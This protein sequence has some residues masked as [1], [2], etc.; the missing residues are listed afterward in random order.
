MKLEKTWWLPEWDT[1]YKDHLHQ[2]HNGNFQYQKE[3]RDFSTSFCKKLGLALDIGG[4]IGFW[5]K[6]LS[7]KFEKVVAFEPHP[8]NIECYKKNMEGHT[9]WQLEEVAL[10]N[11]HQKGATLF[12]SPDESG[13]VSLL[14]HGVQYGNSKRTLKESVLKKLTTD[15]VILDD[16]VNKF[17]Q[18]VDFIKVDCQEHEKEIVLGGLELM[19]KNDSVVVLE[20]PLRN[21]REKEYAEDVASIMLSI[22][23]HRRGNLRKETVFTK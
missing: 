21:D 19:S 10:S 11:K 9:N 7:L 1:H 2:D 23:Y 15:V 5:S 17:D 12:Q 14:S 13:N 22:K 8:D 18:N 6:D 16:Y 3:Q 20:L 4:N